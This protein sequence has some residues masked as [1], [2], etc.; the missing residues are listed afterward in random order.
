[1]ILLLRE[2]YHCENGLGEWGKFTGDIR[3][4]TIP[5]SHG[6]GTLLCLGLAS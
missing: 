2:Q 4:P 3:Q 5:G 6:W 1:M